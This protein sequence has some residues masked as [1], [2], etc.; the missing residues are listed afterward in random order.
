MTPD[1]ID[2]L[3]GK[4]IRGLRLLNGQTMND[5]AEQVGVTYGMIEKY[6]LG[7]R[8]IPTSQAGIFRK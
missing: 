6:E 3:I 2:V 1:P 5:I 8:S 7:I 4:R